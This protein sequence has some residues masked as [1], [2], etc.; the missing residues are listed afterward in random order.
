MTNNKMFWKYGVV[1][2]CFLMVVIL[3]LG[4]LQKE[5]E[6]A[7]PPTSIKDKDKDKE[8]LVIIPEEFV[9]YQDYIEAIGGKPGIRDI[10]TIEATVISITK[11]EVCPDKMDPFA[12]EPTECSIEPYPK[13][14]GIVRVN[15][16]INYIQYSEQTIE[17]T[18]EQ[19][20]GGESPEEGD[21]TPR[22]EGPEYPSEGKEYKPLQEGQEVSTYFLLTVRPAK[23]RYAPINESVGGMASAQE[24]GNT[25]INSEQDIISHAV[26]P[27]KKIFKP[28]PKDGSYYVFTTKIGNFPGIIEKNLP[29]L[30]VGSK[31]RAEIWYDGSLY[32]EEYEVIA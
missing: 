27:V 4:C 19:P 3:S 23:V 26:T 16:I 1:L 15:K 31:F 13:D 12:P 25:K 21:T 7:V 24:S 32:V 20:G 11:T 14:L 6:E 5:S 8:E 28:I 22:Y 9:I 29:G 17:P 18:V 30:E 2:A 10:G